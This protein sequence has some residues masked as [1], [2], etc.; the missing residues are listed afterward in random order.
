MNDVLIRGLALWQAIETWHHGQV[1]ARP[2]SYLRGWTASRWFVVRWLGDLVNCMFCLSHWVGFV[3]VAACVLKPDNVYVQIA[4]QTLAVVRVAQLGND[5][6]H[7]WHRSPPSD[8]ITVD[9]LVAFVDQPGDVT[10]GDF[11]NNQQES[12]ND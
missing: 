2:R 12:E 1:F 10:P 5:L 8:S 9:E 3:I 4:V 6:T 11:S 7:H